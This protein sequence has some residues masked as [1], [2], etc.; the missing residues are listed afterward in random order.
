[1]RRRIFLSCCLLL[2]KIA[3]AAAA[4]FVPGTEDVPLMPGLTTSADKGLTFDKPQG[5]IIEVS[6]GG[7]LKR[8]DVLAFYR[9]SL[10]PLGW[11]E[12]AAQRFVRDGERLSLEIAGND[13][14]LT[15]NFALSPL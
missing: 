9:A 14:N 7:A 1:M 5:R 11:K 15:V 6:T 3:M 8:S 4:N 13:G 2:V 12:V 10:P